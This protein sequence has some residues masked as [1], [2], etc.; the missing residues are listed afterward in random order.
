[1]P[2]IKTFKELEKEL[3]A[4]IVNVQTYKDVELFILT[5]GNFYPGRSRILEEEL[6]ASLIQDAVKGENVQEKAQIVDRIS[7]LDFDRG[8]DWI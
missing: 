8:Y 6:Q 3:H 5:S 2:D 7:K 4:D 1:M